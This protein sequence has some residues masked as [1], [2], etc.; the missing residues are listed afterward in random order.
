MFFDVDPFVD[1]FSD[2]VGRETVQ[3]RRNIPEIKQFRHRVP[4]CALL[5]SGSQVYAIDEELYTFI[6]R[7]CGEIR[8]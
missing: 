5:D 1:L 4:A 3:R 2:N 6:K 8:T 7:H